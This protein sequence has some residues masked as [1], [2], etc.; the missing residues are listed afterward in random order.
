MLLADVVTAGANMSVVLLASVTLPVPKA[1][2]WATP[3]V[4][5]DTVVPPVKVLLP[6]KLKRPVPV[7]IKAPAPDTKPSKPIVL[8]LATSNAPDAPPASTIPRLL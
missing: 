6:P 4:P 5:A 1:T 3:R 2:L 7:L 8:P